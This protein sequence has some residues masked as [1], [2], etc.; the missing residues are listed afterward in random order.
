MLFQSP[1]QAM[2]FVD[3]VLLLAFLAGM[4]GAMALQIIQS[5]VVRLMGRQARRVTRELERG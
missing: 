1:D 5:L 2:H 3:A 4:L